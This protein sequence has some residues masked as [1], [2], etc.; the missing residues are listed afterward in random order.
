MAINSTFYLD[1]A[2]LT[3]ATSV[4]LDSSLLNLAP[5][6]FYSDGTISREQSSGILLTAETCTSCSECVC[7]TVT[8]LQPTTEPWF[9]FTNFDYRN[10][11]GTI[12]EAT[13]SEFGPPMNICAQVGY[14]IRIDTSTPND[15]S[16]EVS[17]A[18]E[19]CCYIP[20]ALRT[21]GDNEG[22]ISCSTESPAFVNFYIYGA[23][24]TCL[25]E[26][27]YI[28]LNTNSILDTFNGLNKYYL[29]YLA[30]CAESEDSYLVQIGTDGYI[31]VIEACPPPPP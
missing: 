6:G 4:Y 23:D 31:T 15:E 2:D 3:L 21:A 25:V 9:G 12:I 8:W 16:M 10:C 28:A 18:V 20:L 26:T 1:A 24:L 7:Y 19:D 11:A 17:E 13:V 30:L 27:G 29:V 5:D 22:D 14:S